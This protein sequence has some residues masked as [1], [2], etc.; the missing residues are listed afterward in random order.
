MEQDEKT[1]AEQ[2]FRFFLSGSMVKPEFATK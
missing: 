1:K 2:S